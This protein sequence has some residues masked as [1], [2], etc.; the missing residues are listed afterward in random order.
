M[1]KVSISGELSIDIPSGK[2]YSG[3]GQL[4]ARPEQLFFADEGMPGT[5][6]FS[7]FL[8]DFIEY[9]VQLDNGQSLIASPHSL[10]LRFDPLRVSLY[11]VESGEVL[12]L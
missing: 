7:T 3:R 2:E 8:G 4:S 1:A 6:L 9:E 12:S 5:I 11:K 10:N